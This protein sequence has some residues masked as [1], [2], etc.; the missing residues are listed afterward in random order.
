[1]SLRSTAVR[2]AAASL[3]LAGV[4]VTTGGAQSAPVE[5]AIPPPSLTLMI[6]GEVIRDASVIT[7]GTT[8]TAVVGGLL[9]PGVGQRELRLDLDA[10]TV[11]E[12]GGVT[13]PEGWTVEWSTDGGTTGS[14]SSRQSP[15]TSRACAPPPRWT[16]ARSTSS[17]QR[18]TK[19][20]N[21]SVPASTFSGS[22]GG[23][24]WDVFFYDDYVLNIFHHN[25][26][27]IGLDCH[28]RS[29]GARCDWVQPDQPGDVAVPRLPDRKPLGRL[30]RR[31]HRIRLRLHHSERDDRAPGT[32]C[33][34]LNVAPPVSCGFTA[35]SA[36][37]QRDIYGYL[38]NAEGVSGRL[39]GSESLNR[40]LLCF[41]PVTDASL[42]RIRRCARRQQTATPAT[43]TC[44]TLGSR[45]VRHDRTRRCTASNA[46]R[47]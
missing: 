20:L 7:T 16:P 35:L 10:A 9:D 27:Y 30:G 19:A 21:A 38:S 43:T 14:R 8:L 42:R 6:D 22:T 32:L 25:S 5:A 3:A 15:Q 46:C 36:E 40:Q 18:Y 29:T 23:D 12:A 33:I 13:A 11:Y 24:G 4:F 47:L 1:M 44:T 2:L 28:L 17:T 41:D 34:D 39:F 31:Q 45:G 37:H 26:S